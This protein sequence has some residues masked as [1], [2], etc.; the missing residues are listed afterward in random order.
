MYSL[1][2][3]RRKLGWI[4]A[5]ATPATVAN[6]A[7]AA[8]HYAA[9]SRQLATLPVAVK[10]DITPYCN[11]RCV[12]CLHA[13]PAGRDALRRQR[14]APEMRMS[15]TD[16]RGVVDELGGRSSAVS[17]YY[18]GEPFCHP[19][20][21]ELC[22]I[23]RQAGLNVHLS[24]HFSFAFSDA[25]IAAIAQSGVTHLSVCVDGLTQATYGVTRRGGNVEVVLDNLRRLCAHRRRTG[26]R[27]P[28]VEV[29]YLIYRHNVH[30]LA[31]ARR[32]FARLGVDRVTAFWGATHNCTDL[33]P[34]AY[35]VRGPRRPA[36]WPRCYWPYFFLVIRYDGAVIP[37]C[38]Y[39]VGLQYADSPE[40]R[41]LGNAFASGVG[42]V[43][44]GP[45]YQ[46]ARRLAADPRACLVDARLRRH[47][48]YGCQ[49]LFHDDRRD[50]V[51]S[52][53]DHTV[54]VTPGPAQ[55]RSASPVIGTNRTP[56]T[57]SRS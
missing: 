38:D 40:A 45:T 28:E 21:D 3:I 7:R 11:L 17:L 30:E 54:A 48:C 41:S 23:A 29:Q 25:R 26:R 4:V 47:F 6:I 5:G 16:F 36:P 13:Q 49:P 50:L 12:S 8:G 18:Y 44:N 53:R 10:I 39:R 2:R 33:D 32:E 19:D 52:G 20:V 9:R 22:G 15:V 37:C 43:W 51:R 27:A 31:T 46:D 14:F 56:N 1:D 34:G 55:S 35:A 57:T 24:S 42:A